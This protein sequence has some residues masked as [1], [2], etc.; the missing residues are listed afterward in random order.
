MTKEAA[1]TDGVGQLINDWSGIE[2]F[3]LNGTMLVLN[4]DDGSVA[5]IN[6]AP[7]WTVSITDESEG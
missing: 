3:Q 4:F 7:G 6:I 2:S 1:V 5:M